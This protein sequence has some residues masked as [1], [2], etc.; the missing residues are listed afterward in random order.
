MNLEDKRVLQE[1]YDELV[2]FLKGLSEQDGKLEEVDSLKT[3]ITEIV[4]NLAEQ[5]EFIERREDDLDDYF[6]DDE[7][8][9]S[10]DGDH[11]TGLS[12]AGWGTDEDYGK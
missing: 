11:I 5:F 3:V 8:D 7:I 4:V 6:V 12:S 9:E 10:M 1:S 2:R